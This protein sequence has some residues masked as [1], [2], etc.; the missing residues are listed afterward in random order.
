M[1][2]LNLSLITGTY[3]TVKKNINRRNFVWTT[4]VSFHDEYFDPFSTIHCRECNVRPSLLQSPIPLSGFNYQPV[5]LEP[6]DAKCLHNPLV[7]KSG[8]AKPS[9]TSKTP[10]SLRKNKTFKSD[11]FDTD[12][13]KK[14]ALFHTTSNVISFLLL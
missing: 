1:T 14:A 3:G 2:I 11:A 4:I 9:L 13:L 7:S 6:E 5:F 8:E 10:L 12:F